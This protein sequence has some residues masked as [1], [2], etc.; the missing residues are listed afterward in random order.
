MFD[1]RTSLHGLYASTSIEQLATKKACVVGSVV[2]CSI[3]LHETSAITKIFLVYKF[4]E[5]YLF[6]FSKNWLVIC[7]NVQTI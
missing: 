4:S 6:L 2:I 1:C 3:V 5:V 7:F